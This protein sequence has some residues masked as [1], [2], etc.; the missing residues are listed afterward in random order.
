MAIYNI[1]QGKC[2]KCGGTNL[3][4]AYTNETSKYIIIP[5]ECRDCGW[6]GVQRLQIQYI[7]TA[8]ADDWQN[9]TDW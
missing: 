2:P 1:E 9:Q 3:E 7:D 5:V 8:D 4:D 6:E